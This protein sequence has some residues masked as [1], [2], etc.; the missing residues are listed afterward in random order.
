MSKTKTSV[1]EKLTNVDFD[2][3]EALAA[4]D[5]KDYNYYDNLTEEQK[6]K[7]KPYMLLIWM[8][9]VKGKDQNLALKQTNR[10]ANTHMFAEKMQDNPKLQWL[11]LCAASLG[12]GKQFREYLPTLSK[13]VVE[14]KKPATREEVVKYFTKLH[15]KVDVKLIDEISKLYIEQQKRT[16]YLAE[17]FPTMKITDLNVLNELITDEEIQEYEKNAGN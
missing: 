15:P 9:S 13:S 8:S 6:R 12:K 11:T 14:Y 2:L 1:D 7:F 16:C 17:K 5:N 3:F 4:I 10:I